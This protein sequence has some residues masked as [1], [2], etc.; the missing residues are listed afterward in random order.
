MKRGTTSIW[1]LAA[2]TILPSAVSTAIYFAAG[3][4]WQGIPSIALFCIVAG[5][6]LML[7]EAAVMLRENKMEY[8]KYGLNVAFSEHT[9]MPWWQIFL[10]GFALFGVAGLATIT[11]APLEDHLMA[12]P[13]GRFWAM[14]P[15]YFR[16][17]DFAAM[18]HY[19]YGVRLLTCILYLIANAFVYPIIEEL[20]FRGYLTQKLKE[21]GVWAPLLVTA[22][23]SFYHWWIPFNNLFRIFIFAIASLVVY[24]KKNICISMVF[25]CMCNLFS[26]IGFINSLMG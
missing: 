12:V 22:A 24:K 9:P 20:Y 2:M 11:V 16:W 19:S 13:S 14:L 23:F 10:W 8:G 4:L 15:P 1:W 6:T 21:H 26:V 7:F 18:M 17:D 5:L 3:C 25:H